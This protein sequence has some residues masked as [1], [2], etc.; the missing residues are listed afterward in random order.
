MFS[1]LDEFKAVWPN[2][3]QIHSHVLL[4]EGF[5]SV[6]L[7]SFLGKPFKR[8]SHFGV[9]RGWEVSWWISQDWI[10]QSAVSCKFPMWSSLGGLPFSPTPLPCDLQPLYLRRFRFMPLA[11]LY[12]HTTR[13]TLSN[14]V[15]C[16]TIGTAR[17]E[18]FRLLWMEVYLH[19]F[20]NISGLGA[21]IQSILFSTYST[22]F[23]LPFPPVSCWLHL[24]LSFD[25][26]VFP[27]PP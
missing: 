24:W 14:G 4:T 5:Q 19:E 10:G 21:W 25:D 15:H 12:F 9:R 8:Y 13:S 2:L 17:V 3:S 26:L 16:V 18:E 11:F 7:V 22:C 6:S 20:S 27:P 1:R 23:T